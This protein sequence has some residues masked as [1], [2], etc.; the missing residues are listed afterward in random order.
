MYSYGPPHMAGQKQDD[1]LGHTYSS[2]VRIQDVALKTCQRRWTIGK[3]GERESRI[4]VLAARH[5]D[6]D[7]DCFWNCFIF[8]F[9]VMLGWFKVL[10][11]SNL[12]RVNSQIKLHCTF[13]YETV[14]KLHP[15]WSNVPRVN[16]QTTPILPT[17]AGTLTAWTVAVTWWMC[18]KQAHTKILRN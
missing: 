16:V 9:L 17:V 1:Q 4:S 2:Y 8:I 10:Q 13:I 6:D 5:D 18:S 7:D 3:S 11:Y 15:E 14:F 12:K